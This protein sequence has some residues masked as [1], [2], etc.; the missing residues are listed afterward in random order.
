MPF[1]PSKLA[2][3][4]EAR[5]VTPDEAAALGGISSSRFREAL[6]GNRVPTVRQICRLSEALAV[7]Y[8]AWF[9]KTFEVTDFPI[10]DFRGTNP[11]PFKPG[12]H[13]KAIS[14]NIRFR[15]FYAELYSRLNLP[16]PDHLSSIEL[17]ENPEQAAQSVR[18]AL[19]LDEFQFT[20]SSKKTFFNK[21]RSRIE[22]LG[23]FVTQDHNIS[24]QI[25]GFALFHKNFTANYIF[26]NSSKRNSGRKSFTI[27]HELAHI[28][29][30]RSAISDDYRSD[31]E[32]EKY[33]NRFA[34]SLLLPRNAIIDFVETS[35]LALEDYD[36][37]VESAK[38]ISDHF[39]VS[40]SA[41]L[42]R[43]YDVGM[44]KRNYFFEFIKGF[45]EDSHADSVKQTQGGGPADGPDQGVIA[46]AHLGQRAGALFAAALDREVVTPLEI[47][48]RTGLSKARIMGMAQ[49]AK[50]QG[51]EL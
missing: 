28:M 50:Q 32:V 15:E 6:E 39:K 14:R 2:Y 7:P 10:T 19:A 36:T 12:V 30:R 25:D 18:F 44:T 26:V 46:T 49:L 51:A 31:N 13:S 8:Y 24:D 45:G 5:G 41:A 22:R 11:A 48:E 4:I 1:Y 40:V 17:D 20:E 38:I 27:A 21:L 35:G 23:I 42:V 47:H 16:A 43:L 29:G 37:A 34:A 3:V 9:S 33:C